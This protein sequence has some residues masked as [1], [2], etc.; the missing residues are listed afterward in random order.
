MV[1]SPSCNVYIYM[2]RF[3][4]KEPVSASSEVASILYDHIQ[5][6]GRSSMCPVGANRH[7]IDSHV[8]GLVTF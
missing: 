2:R 7:T 1:S 6:L 5:T 8:L 3:S 4:S